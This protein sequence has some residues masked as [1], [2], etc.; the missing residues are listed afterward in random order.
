M[1]CPEVTV[2]KKNS[3]RQREKEPIPIWV[4]PDRDYKRF[5][6]YSDVACD[7]R[8]AV[9]CFRPTLLQL[10]CS[11]SLYTNPVSQFFIFMNLGHFVGLP[12]CGVLVGDT[13]PWDGGCGGTNEIRT[14][15]VI[16]VTGNK[17]QWYSKQEINKNESQVEQKKSLKRTGSEKLLFYV[18][19]IS[20]PSNNNNIYLSICCSA[21][22][23]KCNWKSGDYHGDAGLKVENKFH[24]LWTM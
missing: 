7:L 24:T 23:I 6:F 8:C 1:V 22:S 15:W 13:L 21:Y 20:K 9:L 2:V 16:K 18:V 3:L 12:F 11:M 19:L 14:N 10:W 5:P 17:E 4:T